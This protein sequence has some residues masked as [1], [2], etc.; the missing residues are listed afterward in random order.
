MFLPKNVGELYKYLETYP[1]D[2]LVFVQDNQNHEDAVP[3]PFV[4]EYHDDPE[5][6][7]L[8]AASR[9]VSTWLAKN[10]PNASW[11]KPK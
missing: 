2:T 4:V 3:E 9:P 5:P 10:D 6:Y 1:D 8:F 7:L 11:N